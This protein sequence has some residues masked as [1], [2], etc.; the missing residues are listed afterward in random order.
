M[1]V[2]LKILAICLLAVTVFAA[3]TVLYALETRIPG[4]EIVQSQAVPAADIRDQFETLQGQL[5]SGTCTGHV[6]MEEA[7]PELDEST[8][9]TVTLRLRNRCL[10]PMEWIE[11]TVIPEEGDILEERDERPRVLAA[12]SEGDLSVRILNG[13]GKKDSRSIR[14]NYYLLGKLFE[15]EIHIIFDKKAEAQQ[16]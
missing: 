10:F 9:L 4:I 6:F 16:V 3:G 14:I 12:G 8:F 2:F 15:T 1:R 11:A 5:A 13:N 7:T